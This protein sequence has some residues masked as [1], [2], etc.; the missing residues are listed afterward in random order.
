[1]PLRKVIPL[2]ATLVSVL[3][4]DF[5]MTE[6]ITEDIDRDVSCRIGADD[7]IVEDKEIPGEAKTVD[8]DG[9]FIEAGDEEILDAVVM[10]GV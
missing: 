1:M 3:C 6:T 4:T 7:C 9:V 10:A 8:C 5:P 2:S